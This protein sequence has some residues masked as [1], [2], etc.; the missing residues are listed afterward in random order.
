MNYHFKKGDFQIFI[1][2]QKKKLDSSR[3]EDWDGVALG[4]PLPMARLWKTGRHFPPVPTATSGTGHG[5]GIFSGQRKAALWVPLCG[6][7]VP[8]LLLLG[9]RF[10]TT[11]L[12][13]PSLMTQ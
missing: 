10:Q 1:K 6:F 3:C 12:S 13:V 9:Q 5:C 2:G 7:C 4:S 11:P 8:S